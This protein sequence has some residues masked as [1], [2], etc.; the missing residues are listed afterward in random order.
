[1]VAV[2]PRQAG[3]VVTP[4]VKSIEFHGYFHFRS[5]RCA[6]PELQAEHYLESPDLLVWLYSGYTGCPS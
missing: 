6:P 4:V 5:V 3:G 2:F 1:M